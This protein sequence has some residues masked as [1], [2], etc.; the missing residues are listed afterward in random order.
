MNNTFISYSRRD[1]DF[2]RQ[3]VATFNADGRDVWVDWEDIPLTADWMSEIQQGI[4]GADDF[5]FVISPDSVASEVCSQ[6]LAYAVKHNKRLVPLLYREVSD[7]RAIHESLASHNWIMFNKP[8]EFDQSFKAL[9]RA[10]DTDLEYTRTHTR[11]LQRALEWEKRGRNSSLVLSGQDLLESERW[12]ATSGTKIPHVTP[13]QTEYIVESRRRAVRRQSLLGVVLL[14]GFVISMVMAVLAIVSRNEAQVAERRAQDQAVIARDN[15]STAVAAQSLAE[16]AAALADA[17]AADVQS[18]LLAGNASQ[19][20]PTQPELAIVLALEANKMF[21]PPALSQRTLADLSYAPGVKRV[22]KGF[23]GPVTGVSM[24]SDRLKVVSG[25]YD[26]SVIVWDVETGA[27]LFETN[28]QSLPVKSVN[29]NHAGTHVVAGMLDGSVLIWDIT[30]KELINQLGGI[31]ATNGHLATV[32]AVVFTPDDK[33]LISGGSD[34]VIILWDLAAG[35]EIARLQQSSD[36]SALAVSPDGTRLYVGLANAQINVEIWDIASQSRLKSLKKH[37]SPLTSLALNATGTL[38]VSS[39]TNNDLVVWDAVTGNTMRPLGEAFGTYRISSVIT[40]VA[41]TPDNSRVISGSMDGRL[42]IWDVATGKGVLNLSHG[43]D[44]LL[45]LSASLDGRSVVTG[46]EAGDKS[47]LTLWDIDNG[48]I[49]GYLEGHQDSIAAVAYSPDGTYIAT[50]SEDWNV[51][52]WDAQTYDIVHVLEGHK[53]DVQSIAYN[54]DG[55]VLASGG[56]DQV[57]ILWDTVNGTKISEIPVG[58]ARINAL[59]FLQDDRYI[60]TG[61][62]D[63][64]LVIWDTETGEP[65]REFV[66]HARRVLS[67]AISND[68]KAIVSGSAGGELILWDLETGEIRDRLQGQTGRVTT[69]DWSPDDKFIVTG[70]DDGQILLWDMS[71]NSIVTHFESE[72]STVFD[73][74]FSRSGFYILSGEFEGAI[75]LWDVQTGAP[76]RVFNTVHTGPVLGV[77]FS[78]DGRDAVS[79]SRDALAIVWRMPSLTGLIQWIRTNRYIPDLTCQQA[80]FYRLNTNCAE[81]ISAASTT[82]NRDSGSHTR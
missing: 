25:A 4:E 1:I 8:E 5:V 13:L 74:Q 75:K 55:T 56:D 65:T 42:L 46:S 2:V 54:T 41:F 57:I 60:L 3:L 48:A 19:V 80:Q 35:T 81:Q 26:G 34:D 39:S 82:Q 67:M 16:D 43:P 77:T 11:L 28:V 33:T 18:L 45:T 32:N 79:V 21:A 36:V 6:E 63:S 31:R 66:G 78:P 20:A 59:E 10:L 27:K 58:A 53:N 70:S 17:R 22:F 15:A 62:D 44:P 12:L 72:T 51:T 23:K 76:V 68:D 49:K 9:I 38:A 73:V 50:G 24:S 37:G 52:I 29:F 30:T 47:M 71:T 64:R 61:L 7:Y 14:L 69:I 40:G